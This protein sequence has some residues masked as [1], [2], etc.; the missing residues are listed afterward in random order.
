MRHILP[1]VI[2]VDS[3]I[4]VGVVSDTYPVLNLL[5]TKVFK[6]AT[7]YYKMEHSN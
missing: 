3:S 1:R 7:V 5:K 6:S 4:L 2:F